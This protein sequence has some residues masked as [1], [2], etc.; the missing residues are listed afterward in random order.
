[1][2]LN[3]KLPG[4]AEHKWHVA[5]PT[6]SVVVKAKLHGEPKA[7]TNPGELGVEVGVR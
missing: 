3:I 5:H 2:K 7:A 6:T 1:M 4:Q